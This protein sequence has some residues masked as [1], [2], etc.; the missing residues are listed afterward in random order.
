[1]KHP[2][3]YQTKCERCGSP[4][5]RPTQKTKSFK[6]WIVL[7]ERDFMMHNDHPTIYLDKALAD[8]KAKS[9]SLK[10]AVQSCT[11]TYKL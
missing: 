8:V 5:P 4:R 11:V 9:L 1:M 3:H 7:T 2:Q 6:A 10:M